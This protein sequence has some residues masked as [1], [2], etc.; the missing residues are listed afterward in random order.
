[1]PAGAGA[2]RPRRR[3]R[4]RQQRRLHA[5]QRVH[6]ALL[7]GDGHARR[8]Q[9]RVPGIS[10]ARTC[11][12]RARPTRPSSTAWWRG[13]RPTDGCANRGGAVEQLHR[14]RTRPA[15]AGRA[16]QRTGADHL[17]RQGCHRTAAMGQGRPGRHSRL[18]DS[19]PCRPATSC[20]R[21]SQRR[22]WRRS[23]RS[24]T[25]R[26]MRV[27]GYAPNDFRPRPRR[28]RARYADFPPS[29]SRPS[30]RCGWSAHRGRC[31]C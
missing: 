1:M 8:D 7:R 30:A 12:P 16:D 14:T 22:G 18:D 6:S 20:S 5:A 13:P 10:S 26:T 19:K 23:C 11:G 28:I 21:R 3:P 17:G 9:G 4:A 24:S 27:K 29:T 25:Q 15:H 31:R 2:T